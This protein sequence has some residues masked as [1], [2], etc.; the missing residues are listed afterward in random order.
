MS[1]S[2]TRY[3]TL[4]SIDS[5]YK[6]CSEYGF[7]DRKLVGRRK[8][9]QKGSFTSLTE[10]QTIFPGR[11]QFRRVKEDPINN[12]L[13]LIYTHWHHV[14][15]AIYKI[16]AQSIHTITVH[17]LSLEEIAMVAE[18]VIASKQLLV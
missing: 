1:A 5:E 13:T 11:Y 7:D 2:E 16:V 9:L 3:W 10:I 8:T 4:T 12:I 14:N 17:G 18:D 15:H 6:I